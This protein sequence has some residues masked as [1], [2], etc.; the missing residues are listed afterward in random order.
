MDLTKEQKEN[1]KQLGRYFEKL[2]KDAIQNNIDLDVFMSEY[3]DNGYAI[4]MTEQVDLEKKASER[5]KVF[6][7]STKDKTEKTHSA[8]SK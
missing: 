4:Y 3:K 8:K 2:E 1:L 7:K 6:Q 5:K